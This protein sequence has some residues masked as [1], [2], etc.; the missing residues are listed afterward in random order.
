MTSPRKLR[1]LLRGALAAVFAAALLLV[2]ACGSGGGGTAEKFTGTLK[3][4]VFPSFNG[5]GAY[6]ALANKTFDAQGLQ[7]ELIPIATP[8]DA[9][10][11]LI[12][13]QVQFALM[14]LTTPIIAAA[15]GSPF[16]LVA[17]GA[18][19]T[20]IGSDGYGT[21]NLWV[22]GDSDITS[23]AGI[24]G[25]KFGVPQINSQIWLDVRAAI[26]DAGGDSSK[27]QFVETGS[28]GIDQLKG[29]TVDVTTTAEPNGTAVSKDPA[30]KHL[31]GFVSAGGDLA[32]A[33]VATKSFAAAN[34]ELVAKFEAAIIAG[35]K[36]F[37]ADAA[38]QSQIAKLALKQAP[39]QLLSTAR[40]QQYAEEPVS[41]ASIETAAARIERYG[42]LPAGKAPQP[43]DLLPA[44]PAVQ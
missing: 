13:N 37:N 28:A 39:D 14:D 24:A 33:F 6:S 7:V 35:N 16:V 42:L 19:G 10:P 43:A 3:V 12:G 41:A 11:Q 1:L 36:A 23:V 38:A 44:A 30:L 15:N 18:K 9:A 32:Y 2:G 5:L 40:Y 4:G 31:A 29:G 21:A 22:R 8:A 34:P 27:V 26:D 25:H 17:P 20:A